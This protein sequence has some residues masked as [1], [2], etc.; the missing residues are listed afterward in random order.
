MKLQLLKRVFIGSGLLLMS[1]MVVMHMKDVVFQVEA[2]EGT[3]PGEFTSAGF[4]NP[5]VITDLVVS[6]TT[7]DAIKDISLVPQSTYYMNATIQDY[8]G[9]THLDIYFVV[10]FSDAAEITSSLVKEKIDQ[11]VTEESF[12]VRYFTPE[13]STYLMTAPSV[14]TDMTI[15]TAVDNYM[16]KDGSTAVDLSGVS[17]HQDYTSLLLFNAK[18]EHTWSLISGSATVTATELVNAVEM[19]HERDVSIEFITSK[20]AP[21]STGKWHV[22]VVTYD[23]Y[24][25]EIPEPN[26]QELYVYSLF[27]SGYSMAFYGEIQLDSGQQ[28]QFN[29]VLRGLDTWSDS[30]TGVM[31][32]YVAN[33]AF[34]RTATADVRWDATS[35]DA[36]SEEPWAELH[37]PISVDLTRQYFY[38]QVLRDQGANYADLLEIRNDAAFAT[39]STPI[40]ILPAL[41]TDYATNNVQ[42]M[43][44]NVES[45][46]V[47]TSELGQ[48]TPFL[49][50]IKLSPTF[51]NATYNGNMTIGI[52]GG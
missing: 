18:S 51:Q 29:R 31:V 36:F 23:R 1:M 12:V 8:D 25:M 38:L 46:V 50:Q 3:T 13:R 37:D 33:G 44:S 24:Q 28:I 49:F 40:A 43:T 52:T 7:G 42:S 26:S 30:S 11:G 41:G 4:N 9:F 32:R 27:D 22:A 10:F 6:K 15:I 17:D 19:P 34:T 35:Q 21:Q 48:L 16:V 2:S 20:V 5:T 14:L 45:N 47:R 39:P